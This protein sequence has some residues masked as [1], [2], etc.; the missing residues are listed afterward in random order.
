MPRP[1]RLRNLAELRA[2]ERAIAKASGKAERRG[3]KE[4]SKM[5]EIVDEVIRLRDQ[6]RRQQ[7]IIEAAMKVDVWAAATATTHDAD[8]R[9]HP[10]EYEEDCPMCV[11]HKAMEMLNDSQAATKQEAGGEGAT[12]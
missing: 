7:A 11:L 9:L 3:K 6:Q 12:P 8:R 2:Y 5:K 4:S 10:Y 1:L